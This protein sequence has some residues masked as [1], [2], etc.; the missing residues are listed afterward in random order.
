MFCFQA[1]TTVPA[2]LPCR[3]RSQAYLWGWYL[4]AQASAGWAHGPCCQLVPGVTKVLGQSIQVVSIHSHPVKIHRVLQQR[5]ITCQHHDVW[6]GGVSCCGLA[7]FGLGPPLPAPPWALV[8]LPVI[9][10]QVPEVLV[11]P[12]NTH[13]ATCHGIVPLL[14]AAHA[15]CDSSDLCLWQTADTLPQQTRS[16]GSQQLR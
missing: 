12:A 9:G 8:L 5:H 3:T 6:E 16:A 11:A 10:Q 4:V 14:P 2:Y 13:D 1:C 7:G 15:C